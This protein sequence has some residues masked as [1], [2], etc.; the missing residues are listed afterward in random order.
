MK[1]VKCLAISCAVILLA[2]IAF[3]KM[4]TPVLLPSG[5]YKLESKSE[6]NGDDTSSCQGSILVKQITKSK[7]AITFSI[8]KGADS[9][10]S[11]SFIDTLDYKDDI[12]VYKKSD[13]DRSCRIT[14]RFSSKGIH[15]IEQTSGTSFGCGFGHGVVADGFF[16]KVPS[17]VPVLKD[18]DVFNGL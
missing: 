3:Y 5:F 8:N 9:N 13:S 2:A 6:K 12:A 16:K 15:V 14:M 7:L 18:L 4:K 11:R 1:I 10:N 17:K